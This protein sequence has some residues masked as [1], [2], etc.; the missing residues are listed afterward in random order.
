[1]NNDKN[2]LAQDIVKA[3]GGR[4]N[5]DMAKKAV[6]GDTAALLETLSAEDKQKLSA[7]LSDEKAAKEL[8][9]SDAAKMMMKML[10]GGKKNG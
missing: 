10:F 5:S 7:I 4:V 2:R 9:S 3:S 6:S 1:M 8:L